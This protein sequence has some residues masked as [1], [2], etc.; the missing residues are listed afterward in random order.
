MELNRVNPRTRP[1]THGRRYTS[2]PVLCNVPVVQLGV[3]TCK[4]KREVELRLHWV[5]LG[6]FG[7]SE[8]IGS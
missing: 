1:I 7:S 4:K 3:F 5:E 6:G 2:S 8:R